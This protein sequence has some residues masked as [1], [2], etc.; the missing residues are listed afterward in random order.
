M[1]LAALAPGVLE[2]LD[3]TDDLEPNFTEYWSNKHEFSIF[4]DISR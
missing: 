3:A 1:S 2:A 4:N